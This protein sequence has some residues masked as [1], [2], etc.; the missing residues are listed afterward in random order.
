MDPKNSVPQTSGSTGEG[1]I[2]SGQSSSTPPKPKTPPIPSPSSPATPVVPPL[3]NEAAQTVPI[4]IAAPSTSFP[5]RP[6]TDTG[7]KSRTFP[8]KLVLVLLVFF[9]LVGGTVG[10]MFFY[11]NQHKTKV[12]KLVKEEVNKFGELEKIYSEVL[13]LVRT[14][15]QEEERGAD[16]LRALGG[17]RDDSYIGKGVNVLAKKLAA[18]EDDNEE[19]K[20]LVR[21]GIGNIMLDDEAASGQYLAYGRSATTVETYDFD[22]GK[23]DMVQVLGVKDK[24]QEIVLGLEDSEAMASLRKGSELY[25]KGVV[26]ASEIGD[27]N[28]EVKK[29]YGMPLAT[30]YLPEHKDLFTRTEKLSKDTSNLLTYLDEVNKVLIDYFKYIFELTVLF[31]ETIAQAGHST[32]VNRVQTKINELDEIQGRYIA[33]DTSGLSKEVIRDHSDG[34]S[35]FAQVKKMFNDLLTALRRKDA[36]ALVRQLR[37]MTVEGASGSESG[38]VDSVN[39]WQNNKTV[40]S[41]GELK[42]EW[43]T[44]LDSFK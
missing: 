5:S 14:G 32:M 20:L 9:L 44:L 27:L 16:L 35:S 43:K 1:S 42:G 28:L 19:L 38:I 21:A 30:L 23:P 25:R 6:V 31:T 3:P 36:N 12:E 26:I 22:S 24:N 7:V 4:P 41:A 37:A 13:K 40:R 39:F 18:D 33:I 10:G 11:I 29:E 2:S 17:V 34:L 15:G 8:V